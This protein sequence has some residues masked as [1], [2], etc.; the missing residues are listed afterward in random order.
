MIEQLS[1]AELSRWQ[2]EGKP[3]RL[4]DVRFAV[5]KVAA[6]L[7][8]PLIPLPELEERWKEI[9]EGDGPLVVYCHHGVRSLHACHFLQ[10]VG[11]QAMNLRGGIDAWSIEIDPAVARY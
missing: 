4:L 8:G 1:V 7:G 5:E 6:D 9:P 11:V 2:E 3:F 10:A